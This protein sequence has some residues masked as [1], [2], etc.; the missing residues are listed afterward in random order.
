M[1]TRKRKAPDAPRSIYVGLDFGTTFFSLLSP[2]HLSLPPYRYSGIAWAPAEDDINVISSWKTSNLAHG[3]KKK[4]L[5]TILYGDNHRQLSW[6][7]EI[8]PKDV[9]LKWFKLLLIDDEDLPPHIRDSSQ[10]KEAKLQMQTANRHVVQVIGDYIKQL[11][12]VSYQDIERSMGRKQLASVHFHLMV[13]VPAIWPLYARNRMQQALVYAGVLSERSVVGFVSEPE[14]AAVAV[15]RDFGR[16]ACI[17]KNDH[18][19]VC[20]A[21]GGTVDI[22]TYK[23]HR[24]APM[25]LRES[26]KGAGNFCGAVCLDDGFR[27]LLK[28]KLSPIVWPKI[29]RAGINE[30]MVNQWE[31]GIKINHREDVDV[32]V[33][34]AYGDTLIKV[35]ISKEEIANIYKPIVAETVDLVL[36]QIAETKRKFNKNPTVSLT[37]ACFE[38]PADFLSPFQYVILVGGFGKSR[39]LYKALTDA[40]FDH[41]LRIEVLQSQGDNPIFRYDRWTAVCRGALLRGLSQTS[42][43]PWATIDARIARASYG[44]TVNILP[45]TFGEHDARDREW[46]PLEGD[47]LAMNQ[48]QWFIEMGETLAVDSPVVKAF[49]QDVEAPEGEVS[50]E[51]VIS[52]ASPPPYRFN[53][54]VSRLCLIRWAKVPNFASLPRFTNPAGKVVR[55]IPYEIR[56]VPNGMSLDFEIFHDNVMVAS[57]NISVECDRESS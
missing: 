15:V 2:A 13:T 6:G 30:V 39:V 40:V 28:S 33:P 34:V 53:G 43:N 18:F 10:L 23:C 25:Q 37:R 14:A 26:V 49:W 45:W 42:S 52:T 38:P 55:Q 16:R 8:L 46:C 12:K 50:T 32:E 9:P 31:N 29:G 7:Y 1:N 54:N 57:K 51:I 4:V 11:W 41:G 19:V 35:K 22:I 3:D 44:T 27:D 20:D 47:F 5:T 24:E 17:K 36:K 21:G 56:M 48:V